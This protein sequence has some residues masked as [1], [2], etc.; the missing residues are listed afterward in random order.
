MRPPK[1]STWKITVRGPVAARSAASE[2]VTTGVSCVDAV[3]HAE[4]HAVER[5]ARGAGRAPR[6]RGRRVA[7]RALKHGLGDGVQAARAGDEADAPHERGD[8]RHRCRLAR[9][10]APR[11]LGRRRRG[12][13]RV[14]RGRRRVALGRP[15][16]LARQRG[17]Q[18][19]ERRGASRR[20]AR[21]ELAAAGRGEHEAHRYGSAT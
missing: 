6:V 20:G 14:G 3:L 10:E 16:V 12:D 1:G 4:R 15:R 17:G 21:G 19:R 18:G 9:R 13:V 5:P 2:A 11:E 7:Q 8:E